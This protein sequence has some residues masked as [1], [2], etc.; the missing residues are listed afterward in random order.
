MKKTLFCTAV[1]SLLGLSALQ[2][3]PV[4]T[5]PVT[6][7][8]AA[9]GA[10]GT[11]TDTLVPY[12]TF[13]GANFA[14]EQQDKIY[15]NF[16]VGGIPVSSSIRFQ[17]QSI[18]PFDFHTVTLNSNFDPNT[19]FTFS[20]DIAIDPNFGGVNQNLLERI[21][22]V[23]GDISNPPNTGTP[24][25]LKT[26]FSEG[27]TTL[28]TLTSTT[29]SPGGLITLSETA[30]H[31]TDQFTPAG[32]GVVSISNTFLEATPAQLPEPG[33]YVLYTSG[34]LLLGATRWRRRKA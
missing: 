34:L 26:I 17:V 12:S 30:V 20:Y 27:G 3:A 31:V 6:Q 19:N 15:S 7:C 4:L 23:S 8:T 16:N 33:T 22:R 10:V 32:G 29:G 14:C 9:T 25:N 13:S 5:G 24:S 2:A 21:V 11:A 1:C 28:G 18:G